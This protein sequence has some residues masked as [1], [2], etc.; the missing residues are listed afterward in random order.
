MVIHMVVLLVRDGWSGGVGQ[1]GVGSHGGA[2]PEAVRL[3]RAGRDLQDIG[4]LV[5]A[6]ALQTAVDDLQLPT[7]ESVEVVA[8]EGLRLRVRP[9]ASAR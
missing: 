4:R 3:D 1:V 6:E 5:D 7:G 9:A 8:V 2:S